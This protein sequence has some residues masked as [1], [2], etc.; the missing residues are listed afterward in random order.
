MPK[1]H[2]TSRTLGLQPA[3]PRINLTGRTFGRVTVIR[4]VGRTIP[5][6]NK[7]RYYWEVRCLCGNVYLAC[8]GNL[9]NGH[10]TSCGCK[11]TENI[12][13]HGLHKDPLYG[14]WATMKQRCGNPLD[15]AY[16][17]Y[18]GRGITVCDRWLDFIN[19]YDDMSPRPR[20]G[21]LERNNNDQ[22]YSPENCRWATSEEQSSNRSVNRIL[23]LNGIAKTITQ[24]G[25]L[26]GISV[27]AISGRIKRRWS[28][29]R[30]ITTPPKRRQRKT[31]AVNVIH[32]P[33]FIT[34]T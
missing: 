17:L 26:Y 10:A 16:D 1:P 4:F 31:L 3:V 22:G 7:P 20:G 13:R 19:F 30:A 12:T 14:I 11:N 6:N 25:K 18:G 24:W 2:P 32:Y 33:T 5:R 29:E 27:W 34:L 8:A 23:T 9:R 28:I 15:A 21:T